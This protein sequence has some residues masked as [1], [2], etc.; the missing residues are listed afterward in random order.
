MK[1]IHGNEM[2]SASSHVPTDWA[3]I[4]WKRVQKHVR[5]IQIRL[6][7][8][9]QVG[10]WRRV[11][12][13]QRWLTHSFSAQALAVKRVTQNQGKR[14]AGVDRELWNTPLQKY[15]AIATLKKQRYRP[16]PLRRVYIPKSNG[17]MRPLGI[18]TMK[19]RAMQALY[20]LALD[21]VLEAVSDPNS[22]GFRKNRCT[23][24]AM[25]QIFIL[26]SRKVSARWVLD[27]DIEGFFDN[28]NHDWILDNICMDKS[29]L[30]KW[31][32]SGVVD[33]QQL[34]ATTA[35]TPQGGIISP[36]LA[37]WTLNGLETELRQY[38]GKKFGITKA[39]K[40]KVAVVRY[41][42]DFVITGASKEILENDVRPWV[43]TFL[44]TR[45][46]RLSAA[47]T[48]VVHINDGFDFLGWNFRKYS[49]KKS[50]VLL[51]KPSKKN[52]KTFYEKLRNI[53]NDNLGVKQENLIRLLN[54]M[55]RGWSQ[56][57]S[58]VVAKEAFTRMDWLLFHRLMRWAKRRHPTKSADWIRQK[59]WRSIGNRAWVFAVDIINAKGKKDVMEL[60]SL[61]STVI[62]YHKK[63]KGAYNPYDPKCEMY[64]ETLRQERMVN[65]MRYRT[66]WV[67]MY[68]DQRGLCALCGHEMDMD[69]GWHDHHIE[70][71]VDGGSDAL[72][73]R[74]L[75]H[76]NCHTQVH[77]LALKVVKPVPA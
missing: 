74:V 40:L 50:E 55:L 19:D 44:A 69:T 18:P 76:P 71:R 51:I 17:K 36:G 49:R 57:H 39:E 20:L 9:T 72:G 33:R 22:Y 23:A 73:N 8:A 3:S 61:A 75:L 45:G 46:L 56:Y 41:A 34:L 7:K 38:L 15:D 53:I 27:A 64:G 63:I 47:K 13:L 42:D 16:L 26:T 2:G 10:D 4:D 32:K 59:Y 12:A 67:K 43:E 11:K 31:L 58:P 28:I 70:Y 14:T 62:D 54:P 66:E 5:V 24:D 35:G 60:Y 37:N 65:A 52:V 21:P 30:R 68:V 77:S 1:E 29:I 48:K 25:S 6:V